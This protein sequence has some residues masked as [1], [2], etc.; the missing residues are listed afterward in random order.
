MVNCTAMQNTLAATYAEAG[1]RIW[2][3]HGFA[4]HQLSSYG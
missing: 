2:V 1:S 4:G 3:G